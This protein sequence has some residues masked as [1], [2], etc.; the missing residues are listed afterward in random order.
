MST[1]G[2]ITVATG[3][4]YCRLAQNLAMSY[5]LF[6]NRTYPLY[7]ITDQKGAKMLRRYFDGVVVME[8]PT[9]TFM[10]KIA[11]YENTPFDETVF[12]DA[13][14]NI[15]D[16]ISFLFDDFE[17][18]GSEFSC[19]G[20]RREI[21]ETMR[22]NHFGDEAIQSLGLTHFIAFNGGVYYFKKSPEADECI[23]YIYDELVPLYGD[24]KMKVFRIGQ[25][26][27]EPLCGLAMEVL[28]MRP[29]DTDKDLMKLIQDIRTYSWDMNRR[30]C[31]FIWYGKRVSP[32]MPHY[33]THNTRT[34]EYVY[35]NDNE[36][37]ECFLFKDCVLG[38]F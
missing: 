11:V 19:I 36:K 24:Y 8:S 15:V 21:T 2:F 27:D 3:S 17:Q 7:A 23:R 1:R 31:S 4:Y 28:G 14:M 5:R 38:F 9:Y 37:I 10:D 13:D 34:K 25:M 18:N 26:A 20:E 35:F 16:D 6:T 29:L 30:K 12:I 33:G 22:P 32:L